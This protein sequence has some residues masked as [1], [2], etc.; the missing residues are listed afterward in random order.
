MW[1]P[2]YARSVF[3]REYALFW[4]IPPSLLSLYYTFFTKPVAFTGIYVS[5]FFNPHVG[6]VPGVDLEYENVA[7]SAHNIILLVALV[8]IY[9]AFCCLF[10]SKAFFQVLLISGVNATAAAV[11]VYMQYNQASEFLI[12]VAQMAWHSAHAQF[13]MVRA[14]HRG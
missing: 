6:Y 1:S 12:V 7:H 3:A 8:G 11:Y 13:G 5:W 4:L 10:Y 14:G 2:K 9:L